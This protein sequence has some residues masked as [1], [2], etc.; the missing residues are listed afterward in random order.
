[1]S[2]YPKWVTPHDRHLVRHG[3]HISAPSFPEL[4][5]GRSDNVVTVLVRDAEQEAFA[6]SAADMESAPSQE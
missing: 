6:L 4:N 3:D 1:M 2:E 5:V